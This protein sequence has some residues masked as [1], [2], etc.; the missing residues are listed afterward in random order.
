CEHEWQDA[1]WKPDRWG[2]KDDDKPGEK[3]RTNGGSL[4]HRGGMKQQA[5]CKCGAWRGCF[6]L[7][8]TPE[9]YVQHAVEIF[10]EVRRVLRDDGTL[11]LNLGDSYNAYNHNRG[12]AKGANKNHHE[13]M[14]MAKQGLSCPSLKPKDLVGIPWRVA[15][16]LQ[17]DGWY[18][19]SEG[20]WGKKAPMPESVRD[21][22][23]KAHEQVFRLAKQERYFYDQVAAAEKAVGGTPGNINHKGKTAYLNGDEKHRT[24]L[25]L[26]EMG[27]VEVRNLRSVWMLSPEPFSGAHFATMPT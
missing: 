22:P 18:L 15:F 19:R 6:G 13:V 26:T 10:R 9:L 14:P 17:A 20:I 25:G 21:R 12:P 8:P 4:G 3:Q 27:A 11:W 23:T 2:D 1:S 5:V 7:E 24:K 16:A